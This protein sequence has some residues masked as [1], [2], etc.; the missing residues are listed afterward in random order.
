MPTYHSLP[1][2]E[3]E[4]KPVDNNFMEDILQLSVEESLH[5]VG[6][7][8]LVIQNDYFPGRNQ[9]KIWRYKDLLQIGKLVKIGFSSSTTESPDFEDENKSYVLEG[10]ITTIETNFTGKSQAPVIIRGYDVSHRLYRGKHNR[11][12]QNMT[13]S[14][15]VKK[16][17][18]EAAI[19]IGKVDASGV[20]HEY[21]FQSNQ[22]NME[23]LRERT[24]RIGFELFIQDGK[25]NF[26]KPKADSEELSLKWLTDLHSFRIRVT[27][28][29]Q[30]KEVEVRGWDYSQKKP[31][32]STAK[33]ANVIT[34][35][36][37]G[38]GSKISD[39]FNGISTPKMIIVDQPVFNPKEASVIAQALCN[40]LGGQ[41][42]N[43]DAKA[44]GNTKIRPG[45]VVNLQEMGQHSGKYYITET[46]HIYS[47][48][49]YS[50]EF[51]VRSSRGGNLLTVLAPPN[52]P[53]P[54]NT[55]LVG[56]VTDNED[57]E[58]WGRVKVKFPTMTEDHASNWAR[59]VTPGAGPNRGIYW[60]PEIN[61]EVLVAF[62]HGD[63]HRPYI[64][65]GVWN[66][67]DPTPRKI[68][69]TV[70]EGKVRL[71]GSTTRFG[72]K[73]WFVDD[74]KGDEKRGYYIQTG[75]GSGH[76]LRFNDTEKI[77]EIQTA[78][79]HKIR[80][81]DAGKTITVSSTG[82]LKLEAQGN[83]D[84]NAGG[85]ITVKGAIIK[86]N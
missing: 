53:Q 30:V 42:I 62:E 66:G 27:S 83:I 51:S 84:I 5:R 32:V 56:I 68:G 58:G 59:I 18:E 14:D 64:I 11:S 15:I 78:G 39:K 79:G 13:D 72:H 4:G 35:T 7:F 61:D 40:E 63:M 86:L 23:L 50:T 17:A 12:F 29:E 74:D 1:K 57:P 43:A 47:E 80:M 60:L 9:D 21:I 81:D 73:A 22:T 19:K 49:V 6:M 41:F 48:R 52:K 10:E 26:R 67:T 76:W 3:I 70:V 65:G 34:D 36:Q 69:D 55:F 37:N 46:R 38:I 75:T 33:S 77:I 20:V 44:E 45:T 54:G 16:I 28:A 24:A 85:V 31:I 8:T 82:N 25:L 2:L 71:R